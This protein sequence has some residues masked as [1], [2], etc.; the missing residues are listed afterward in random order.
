MRRIMLLV[1]LHLGVGL[2]SSAQ[3]LT[4]NDGS[5]INS[6]PQKIG[7]NLG[8]CD[9]YDNA[10]VMTN[11][12]WCGGNPG[13]EPS[14]TRNIQPLQ[15][16]GTRTTFSDENKYDGSIVNLWAGA[17]FTVT[18]SASG[19]AEL[20][21]TGTII[22]NTGPNRFQITAG[23]YVSASNQVTLV[24]NNN[25]VTGAVFQGYYFS[26]ALNFLN[27][28]N[29]TVVSATSTSIVATYSGTH[30][31]VATTPTNNYGQIIGSTPFFAPVYTI[32]PITNQGSSGCAAAFAI[33]D[34]IVTEQQV[35]PTP[36]LWWESGFMVGVNGPGGTGTYQYLSNTTDLCATCGQQTLLLN[37]GTGSSTATWNNNFDNNTGDIFSLFDSTATIS[38]WAKAESGA[39]TIT[40][41]LRRSSSAN[42]LNCSANTVTPTG[43]WTQYSYTC[44]GTEL[45]IRDGNP[46]CVAGG[47]T[48]ACTTPAIVNIT[49]TAACTGGTACSVAF[50]NLSV[51][52]ASDTTGNASG[53]RKD[54]IDSWKAMHI[55]VFRDW[56]SSAMNGN[57]IDNWIRPDYAIQPS[58][59]GTSNSSYMFG[60]QDAIP[61]NDLLVALSGAGIDPYL[62][63]PIPMTADEATNLIEFLASPS[64]TT[65]GAKRAALGRSAPWT[66]AFHKIHLIPCDECW[67]PAFVKQNLE[68]GNQPNSETYWFYS[69]EI[70]PLF[71]AMRADPYFSEN[72]F[73]LGMDLWTAVPATANVAISRALPDAVE[74]QNYLYHTVNSDTSDE[75]MW[76]PLVPDAYL[77]VYGPGNE[78]KTNWYNSMQ[79]Y[80]TYNLCGPNGTAACIVN[81]YEWGQ[82]TINGTLSQASEDSVDAGG[83]TGLVDVIK[84]LLDEQ[85]YPNTIGV[86]A[87][88][89]QNEFANGGSNKNIAKLWGNVVDMGG[90]TGNVR[91]SFL[92][93]SAAN[94]AIIGPM[95]SCT[96]DSSNLYNYAGNANNGENVPPGIA[97]I[98]NLPY[99]FPFCFYSGSMRSLILANSDVLNPHTIT[100]T[101]TNVPAG[102][103]TET[104]Y[105]PSSPDVLNEAN[106]G[107]TSYLTPQAVH[108]TTSTVS[109]PSNVII[110]AYSIVYLS[111]STGSTPTLTPPTFSPAA[112]TYASTQN[113]T[114]T[115]PSGTGGCFTVDGST[116]L[117]VVAGA[118]SHGTVYSG[119]ITVANSL[120][121]QAISTEIGFINSSI[122]SA[123]YTINTPTA[124]TPAFSPPVGNYT[125]VQTVV[126]SDATPASTIY[127]TTDGST[128]TT[129]SASYSMPITLATT[130]TI[131]AIAVA[132]GYLQSAVGSGMYTI[133]LPSSSVLGFSGTA[134][135]T[136]NVIFQ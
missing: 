23:S 63:I 60:G 127:Y 109:N 130:T 61:L 115:L 15:A 113:V 70:K 12:L 75:D 128:P 26:P 106:T 19:G 122:A 96:L 93:M 117:A 53:I 39:P 17:T 91:P 118:C 129:A 37:L 88:F 79:L 97:S 47:T 10:Q 69:T 54:V 73:E 43:T 48:T 41:R 136:G 22:S 103:V 35:I 62:E 55:S 16:A 116:P 38:F 28:Q 89:A 46:N 32:S 98:S 121:I 2:T 86:Q 84:P 74:I 31:D 68:G 21:C 134:T 34:V 1:A 8:A 87:F 36:E 27:G 100:F 50:D 25:L 5:V 42:G 67:N 9:N 78:E 30:A 6:A 58:S 94:A 119:V 51:T 107:S 111:Y 90:A 114:L 33:G 24:S 80:K 82:G 125:S 72:N 120:T 57:T 112:G 29:L 4:L 101:G 83:G 123:T 99:V 133:N 20:G 135:I 92:A 108:L 95:Y 132:S 52:R 7:I 40:S 64:T 44:A 76:G 104:F 18:A 110:P 11:L 85:V 71:A 45:G 126:I 66:S 13:F 131:K 81:I 102:V 59:I 124:N 49:L 77:T 56:D 105:A 65:Y 14:Q 3:V